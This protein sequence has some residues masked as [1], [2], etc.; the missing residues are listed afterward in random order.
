MVT[1]K[2]SI[3]TWQFCQF[4]NCSHLSPEM[5]FILVYNVHFNISVRRGGRD[6]AERT[7]SCNNL[8]DMALIGFWP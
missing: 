2:I 6:D 3:L 7:I 8:T 5:W 1:G 4:I